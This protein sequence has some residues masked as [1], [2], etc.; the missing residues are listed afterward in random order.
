MKSVVLLR[1]VMS[2]S[3]KTEGLKEGFFL[4]RYGVRFAIRSEPELKLEQIIGD[5]FVAF[6]SVRVYQQLADRLIALV[7]RWDLS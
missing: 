2:V 4:I 3:G 5:E 6:V 7:S 1:V